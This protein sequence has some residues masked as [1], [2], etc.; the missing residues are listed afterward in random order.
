MHLDKRRLFG[1]FFPILSRAKHSEASRFLVATAALPSQLVRARHN[2]PY[3]A[4]DLNARKGMGA[5]VS[6]ALLIC[7]YAERN[8]LIPLI[9][10]TNPL[11]AST[12]GADFL[13]NYL[14]IASEYPTKNIWPMQFHTLWSFYHLPFS[15][16]ASL[17]DANRLFWKYLSPKPIITDKVKAC[18]DSVPAKQFDLSIHY[19]G[20]DKSL[21]APLPTYEVYEHSIIH[22]EQPYGKVDN[23][24]LATDDAGFEAFIRKRFPLK[25]FVTFNL[26]DPSDT[27]RGRHFSD[28]SPENKAIEA[29][30]NMFLLAAAPACIRGASYMSAISKIINRKLMTIT[31]NRTHG[32]S[33]LFPE[34]EIENEAR[35]SKQLHSVAAYRT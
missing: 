33:N 7:N 3:F 30:V 5:V 17:A 6:E 12:K 28:L 35:A 29:L 23:I 8:G 21:E 22:Y 16:H 14:G 15:R 11:Y 10:S 32:G 18:L 24:F 9:T 34:Y 27:S 4:V 13:T 19:R 26:G 25:R 1:P 2:K 31:V 20:T